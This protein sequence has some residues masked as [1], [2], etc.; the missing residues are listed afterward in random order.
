MRFS[1]SRGLKQATAIA[2]LICMIGGTWGAITQTAATASTPTTVP[3]AVYRAHKGDRLPQTVGFSSYRK[4]TGAT[5]IGSSTHK[6]PPLGCDP[7]FSP[8]AAPNLG[9]IFKRCLA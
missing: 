8:I 5:D 7:A 9:H 4:D 3:T 2:G 6:R 1:L